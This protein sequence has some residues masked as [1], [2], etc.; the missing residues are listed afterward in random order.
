MD[1]DVSDIQVCY[2]TN[3]LLVPIKAA[4][5]ILSKTNV[6]CAY[7]GSVVLGPQL[8]EDNIASLFK[9]END[10]LLLIKYISYLTPD[11]PKLFA[12]LDG[13]YILALLASSDLHTMMFVL[14]PVHLYRAECH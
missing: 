11:K 8:T 3:A 4:W 13:R 7:D 12:E 10:I 6:K 14:S 5:L 1:I 9:V 2:T